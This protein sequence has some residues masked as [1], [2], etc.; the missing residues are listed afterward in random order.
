MVM[1]VAKEAD[2][3][4]GMALNRECMYKIFTLSALQHQ[5]EQ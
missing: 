1:S 3:N 4:E 5:V 2:K